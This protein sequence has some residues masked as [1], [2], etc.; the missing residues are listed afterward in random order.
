M[1]R[2]L[3]FLHIPKSGGTSVYRV[4]RD[5]Y[6]SGMCPHRLWRQL[7]KFEP[8]SPREYMAFAGHFYL[9]LDRFLDM[10]TRKFT[11]LR[12]PVERAISHLEHIVGEKA[13][14]LNS[15]FTSF[16]G[17]ED[18][19]QSEI[20]RE[21]FSEFQVK[22]LSRSPDVAAIA[23][24]LSIDEIEARAIELQVEHVSEVN[25]VHLDSA[26]SKLDTFDKVIDFASFPGALASYLEALTGKKTEIPHLNQKPSGRIKLNV[27]PDARAL[28]TAMNKL[29]T[30]LY[31]H[32][33]MK[34]K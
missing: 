34:A 11:I 20:G 1:K 21:L 6:G 24:K 14:H 15:Y 26:I 2:P 22:M 13:H 17:V 7:A 9:A 3:Y 19:I 28:L 23:G 32:Y 10:E 5:L 25:S 12:D 33:R 30:E 16:R 18:M 29:D 31:D 4:M 27:H 8:H